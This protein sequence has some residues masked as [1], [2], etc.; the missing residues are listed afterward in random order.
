MQYPDPKD[1]YNAPEHYR[2][3]S[4]MDNFVN[5]VNSSWH[6]ADAIELASYVL[7]RLCAIH[8]FINGNGRTARAACYFTICVKSGGL[9]P[10]Q[11]NMTTLL[12]KH[13]NYNKALKEVDANFGNDLSPIRTMVEACL[14]DQLSSSAVPVDAAK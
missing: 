11:E 6:Q 3:H 10:G 5:V 2:V 1:N 13:P 14:K 7:W 12:K 8:P 9:L 4:L